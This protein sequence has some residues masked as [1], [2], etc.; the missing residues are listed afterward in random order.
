M[1]QAVRV[2]MVG[3]A[4]SAGAGVARSRVVARVPMVAFT[5]KRRRDQGEAGECKSKKGGR[6]M[7]GKLA[8]EQF[9]VGGPP[10]AM[11]R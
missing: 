2:V 8:G 5:Q 11:E 3:P 4:D 6:A 9:S 10:N 1:V 7:V